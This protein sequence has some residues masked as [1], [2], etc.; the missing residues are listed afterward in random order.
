[1]KTFIKEWRW[2]I[3]SGIGILVFGFVLRFYHLNLLP[4][5]ADE[6]IYIRWSQIMSAEPT[7]RFLPLS[8]GK[9]P[10][11][12][13]ILMF[14]VKRVSDPLFAGRILSVVS[15]LGT[16]IGIFAVSYLLFKN[17][18]TSLISAL[19]WA[20]SPFSFFF[21][22]MA[23]V[24]AM[25]AMFAVWT[26]FFAILTAKTRR[27]DFAMITG[28][29]L[30]FSLLTKSPALFITLLIPTTFIF[31]EKKSQII[32]LLPML[33]V[34]YLIGYGMYNI[35]RLGPNFN[36]IASRNQDYIL[37]ISHIWTNP[38]DPF[39]FHIEETFKD[40]FIKMGPWPVLGLGLIGL[41][42]SWRKYSKEVVFLTIWFLFP[43][44]VESMFGRVFTVRY[45]L[46][47]LPAFF[48]LAGVSFLQEKKQFLILN[49]LLSILFIGISL[50]FDYKLLTNPDKANLPSSERS[51]YLEEWTAGTG[52]KEISGIIKSEQAR[53]PKEKI[54][55]GTE[56]YFGTLPDGLQMYLA[57]TPSVTVIGTGLDFSQIPQSLIESLKF[58]NKTYLAVNSSRLKIKPEDFAKNGLK[59]IASYKKSDRREK[60]THEYIWYG[61]YDTFYLFEIN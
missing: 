28:F 34:T 44:L 56:G 3:L 55:V 11:F 31:V 59:I 18:L 22:R 13:W 26:M 38:K 4:V 19:I 30:G 48:I 25:L 16:M 7:L 10:L 51:G 41:L 12:M 54:V 39:M 6:A 35:L 47:T 49:Y 21:D 15:G 46:F 29:A 27:L 40:W 24:D 43:I 37:P 45:I 52:I 36:L 9:Q 14:I 58:G 50:F 2:V 32:K 53:N 5:F 42:V 23:L 61:L 57:D 33:L 20:I 17:K 60:D 1:M 8:D